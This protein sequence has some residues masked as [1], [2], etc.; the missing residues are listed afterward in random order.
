[1]ACGD[2]LRLPPKELKDFQRK[3]AKAELKAY[4]SDRELSSQCSRTVSDYFLSSDEYKNAPVIFSYMAMKDEIDLSIIMK[5]ALDDGKNL[6]VP[7]MYPDS[8]D[9]DFYYIDS[10]DESFSCDN[11]YNIKEPSEKSR[12]VEVAS[13]PGNSVF[14]CP[15]LAFNLEGA[16][17]GRGK[18]YYDKY[19]SRVK[20]NVILCGVCTVNVITKAIPCEENDIRMTHLLNEYGFISLHR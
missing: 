2:E 7:G 19:L 5:K 4:F 15:G 14:L 20:S 9:M 13:I 11:K 16:R 12:K 1:M 3:R 18:G 17:L 10:L 6:C 8:N